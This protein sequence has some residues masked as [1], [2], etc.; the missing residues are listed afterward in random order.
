MPAARAGQNGVAGIA[1]GQAGMHQLISL[2]RLFT[3]QATNRLVIGIGRDPT[4]GLDGWFHEIPR[5]KKLWCSPKLG[6]HSSS[7][8]K[9]ISPAGRVP[10]KPCWAVLFLVKRRTFACSSVNP[11]RTLQVVPLSCTA[12]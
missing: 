2:Q 8:G 10:G 5:G 4:R 6:W 3:T 11:S 12:D 9:S 7:L 1:G